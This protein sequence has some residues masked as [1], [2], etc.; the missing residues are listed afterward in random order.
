VNKHWS[1][2]PKKISLKRAAPIQTHNVKLFLSL[3]AF[4]NSLQLERS[5][6]TKDHLYD[7]HAT[8]AIADFRYE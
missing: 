5:G 7:R 6:E 4:G 2:P 1:W 3:D 8:R